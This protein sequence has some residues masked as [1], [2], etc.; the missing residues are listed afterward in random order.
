MFIAMHFVRHPVYIVDRE[1]ELAKVVVKKEDIE[2]I[3]RATQM[4][5]YI[6]Q[7]YRIW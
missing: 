6:R 1:K 7:K 4:R 5:I 3:V 2:L